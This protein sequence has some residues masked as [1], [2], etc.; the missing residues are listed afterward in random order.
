MTSRTSNELFRTARQ[1]KGMSRQR[2]AEAVNAMAGEDPD[3]LMGP[4]A[5]ARIE[6]GHVRWPREGR[7]RAL[8]QILGVASDADLGLYDSRATGAALTQ[9]P[10]EDLGQRLRRPDR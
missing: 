4:A 6:Q 9:E 3:R 7:R 1:R 8:R 2:L 10:D 5:V